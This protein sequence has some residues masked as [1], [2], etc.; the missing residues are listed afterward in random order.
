MNRSK[1]IN[2]GRLTVIR[3]RHPRAGLAPQVALRWL[4]L[5]LALVAVFVVGPARADVVERDFNGQDETMRFEDESM[6]GVSSMASGDVVRLR[7][8]PARA[9]LIR[10]RTQF[11]AE[12]AKSVERL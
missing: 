5:P 1:G 7:L 6:L 3:P 8:P 12:L 9:L 2:E 10:P 4:L 11:L